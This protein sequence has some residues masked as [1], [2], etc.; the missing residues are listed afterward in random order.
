MEAFITSLYNLIHNKALI[1][2]RLVSE[3]RYQT[4]HYGSCLLF[5]SHTSVPKHTHRHTHTKYCSSLFSDWSF[6]QY[7]GLIGSHCQGANVLLWWSSR[8]CVT[9]LRLFIIL[10]YYTCNRHRVHY[11]FICRLRPLSNYTPLECQILPPASNIAK[12]Y[13][14]MKRKT[15]NSLTEIIFNICDM[16]VI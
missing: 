8:C 9:F 7:Q 16:C 5:F 12:V 2:T 15:C 11:K 14:V 1:A 6:T 4:A 13:I 10:S 3:T